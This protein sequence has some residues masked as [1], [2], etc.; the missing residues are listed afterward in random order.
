M[1]RTGVATAGLGVVVVVGG[2]DCL[3]GFFGG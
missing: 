2:N 1:P 3:V